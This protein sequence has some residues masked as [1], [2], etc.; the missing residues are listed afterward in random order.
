MSRSVFHVVVPGLVALIV[1]AID[2]SAVSAASCR[3]EDPT[4]LRN[5]EYG[6]IHDNAVTLR[7][8]IYEGRPF[9]PGGASRPRVELL[10]LV[11]VFLSNGPRGSGHL[12][13]FGPRS[14]RSTSSPTRS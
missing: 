2:P 7:D 10:D 14:S 11:P 8:G 1:A 4:A 6:G 5:I 9:F 3:L 12:F 13:G